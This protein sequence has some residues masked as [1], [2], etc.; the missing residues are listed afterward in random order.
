MNRDFLA[1]GKMRVGVNEN[2]SYKQNK[3]VLLLSCK[4]EKV[5]LK[6]MTER[7]DMHT[8]TMLNA[9]I[10]LNNAQTQTESACKV[11]SH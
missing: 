2:A 5:V 6:Q 7:Q 9:T 8:C 4:T 11:W 1:N 3:S 10:P